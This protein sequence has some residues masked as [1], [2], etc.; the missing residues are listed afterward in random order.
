VPDAAIDDSR[1][2]TGPSLLLDR[3]G[4]ILEIACPADATDGLIAAWREEAARMLEAVG[5]GGETLAARAY[6]GGASLAFTAPVDVLFA[7]TEVNDRAADAAVA[8]VGGSP[9]A[10]FAEALERIL[11]EI[12][13]E[14][15]P[16]LLRLREAAL[17]RGVRFLM[18]EDLV[19]VGLG[20]GARTFPVGEIP[21]PDSIDWS[22][23][24]D[25][26]VALVTGTNGK[27]TTVRLL[28]SMVRAAALVPGFS[29]TDGVVIDG[30]TVETGDYSGPEGARRAMRDPRVDVALLETARGGILRRGLAVDRADVALVTNVTEDHFGEYGVTDLVDLAR[31]KLTVARA[32][33]PDCL[34]VLNAED[35]LLRE[36][37]GEVAAPTAW[38]ALDGAALGP[39]GEAAW[40]DGDTLVLR[41]D[42]ERTDLLTVAEIPIAFGGAARHNVANALAAILVATRLGI[43]TDSMA[44][45]LRAFSGSPDENPGRGNVME[46]GG[47]KILLDFAHNPPGYRAL[48]DIADT[49]PANRRGLVLG[50]PGDRTDSSIREIV[51]IV[52]DARPDRVVVKEVLS[53]L[54]G[55]EEGEI[56]D[57]IEAELLKLGTRPE[58]VV[59][60]D[61]EIAAA[62]EALHWAKEGDLLLF[63]IH[64]ARV[65][66]LDLVDRLR[67]EGW[68]A[69]DELPDCP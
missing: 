13:E 20:R 6:P 40:L 32:V 68:T 2:L 55:R 18:D 46:V 7:A 52:R 30:E 39:D 49:I 59:R 47:V 37:A 53:L 51:R 36:H 54:R 11:A 50:A 42:G 24:R 44:E 17:R 69:G 58:D 3:P 31:A 1:R 67:R 61:S 66:I 57:L 48:F 5:W 12:A 56:P 10:D 16:A 19:S 9:P 60:A 35:A 65:E 34:L 33:G 23:V 43:D 26:P 15:N 63:P 14:R 8:R 27:S 4:A 45:G 38:F 28:A 41:R 29:S 22:A 64:K 62:R 25:V 21:D